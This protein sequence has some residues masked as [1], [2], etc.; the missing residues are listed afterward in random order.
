MYNKTVYSFVIK[1]RPLYFPT[2]HIYYK[3]LL[4]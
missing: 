4:Q 3:L 2:N 1:Q